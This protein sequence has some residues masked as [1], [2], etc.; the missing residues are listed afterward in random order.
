[1]PN[2]LKSFLP[3]LLSLA[4]MLLVTIAYFAP[5]VFQDKRV[6]SSD[7]TQS[8]GMQA[9][10]RKY[11]AD[12]GTYPLWTNGMFGGMPTYQ[13]QYETQSLMEPANKTM[14]LGNVMS[15][16]WP[17]IFLMM[18]GFY[19]LLLVM[20][21][22]WRLAAPISIAYGIAT[23]HI[24]L[25]AA[26]H[27]TKLVALAYLAPIIGSALLT[28]RGRYLL[29][30]G[31][32]AFF[33]GCQIFANH[34]QIT[35]YTYL[36]LLI[37]GVVHLV[38]AFKTDRLAH[39]GKA[40]GVL[41][42]A[43]VLAVGSNIGRLWTTYEYT[44][45]TI[46]G[47]SELT[48]KGPYASGNED[49][50][51]GLSKVYIFQWSYGK[52][53]TFS[54]LIPNFM[55]G[56]S[57]SYFFQDPESA[58]S[59]VL[60]GM[61]DRAAV[62]QLARATGHYW[63]DQPF[64]GGPIYFGAVMWLLF[65]VGCFLVRGPARAWLVGATVFTMMLGW[66]DNFKI[67]NYFLVDYVP[68][69][70]KFRAVTMVLGVTQFTL[71]F[72]GVLGL[73]EVFNE[74]LPLAQRKRG[75]LLGGAVTAGLV[76]I[77]LLLSFT[78]DF[79]STAERAANL[80]AELREAVA[81]DRAALLRADAWRSLLFIGLGL[82]ALYLFV[83]RKVSAVTAVLLVGLFAAV[84]H[85]GIA[86]T[87]LS[88]D[89]F[90]ETTDIE[91]TLE[92]LPVDRQIQQDPD[93][94]Y[95]VADFRSQQ[96]SFSYAIPSLHHRT[97]GGYHAAKLMRFNE[98]LNYLYDPNTY[99]H[100]YDLLNAKYFVVPPQGPDDLPRAQVNPNA[101]GNAWFVD[102]LR[103]VPTVDE[104]YA[105]IADFEPGSEAIVAQPYADGLANFQPQ[106]DSTAQIRLTSYHPDTLRYAYT[107]G[108]EQ[109]AVFSEVY[110][111]PSKGWTV[112][113]DGEPYDAFTKVN[114]IARG[115]KLPAGEHTLEMI[116]APKSY[117][118][119][120][121]IALI[122]SILVL[123]GLIAG[124]VFFFRGNRSD[125]SPEPLPVMERTVAGAGATPKKA[126]PTAARRAKGKRKK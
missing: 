92:P 103:I 109:F 8:R 123:L 100:L 33:V 18:A 69:F 106:P 98:M 88:Y 76:V 12:D 82:G 112:L 83:V 57:R 29:G 94:H 99:G 64:T 75:V 4:V 67:L 90:Q 3:H 42:L 113:L 2:A 125:L 63:G 104:E 70:N 45:E 21:T 118:T 14:L 111:P 102:R 105:A 41:L 60:D 39:V 65:F 71:L 43:T 55:G 53:E 10:M 119:G 97:I 26:G 22:D 54:T 72:L 61:T 84:D 49:G 25:V 20:R 37:M 51:D 114:F 24:D 68:M 91:A 15:V 81:A 17:P 120:E 93:L 79:A 107:A 87:Y 46:R 96:N 108:S 101:L 116:F 36:V 126:K 5:A 7:I 38:N 32:F 95:R 35:F 110:Y 80:P 85:W 13:L 50:E 56:S 27:M 122:A 6:G 19:F 9:E 44:S 58:S 11:R 78:M 31:L 48:D 66:G 1:M 62:S 115:L 23:Y 74:A 124:L 52:L 86:K 28:L 73:R 121:T 16:S 34:L 40:A 77:A 89:D 47:E 30:G 59:Q 117:F